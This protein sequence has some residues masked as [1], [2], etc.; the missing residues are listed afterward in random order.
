MAIQSLKD[1]DA[2]LADADNDDDDLDTTP[3]SSPQPRTSTPNAGEGVFF[4]SSADSS[5][6]TI[7]MSVSADRSSTGEEQG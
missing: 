7:G 2:T 6:S 1:L 5:P 3:V 4:E